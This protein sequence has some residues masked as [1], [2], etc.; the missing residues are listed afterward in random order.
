MLP[1]SGPTRVEALFAHAPGASEPGGAGAGSCLL[2]F[3]PG[4]NIVLL[5]SEPRDGW[6]YGLNE[7]TGRWVPS[8]HLNNVA[9]SEVMQCCS[10][11]CSILEILAQSCE[12][13]LVL[14]H[15]EFPKSLPNGTKWNSPWQERLVPVLLHSASSKQVG[16]SREVS[17][18]KPMFICL[19]CW[20]TLTISFHYTLLNNDSC[21]CTTNEEEKKILFQKNCPSCH[22]IPPFLPSSLLHPAP[23]SCLKPTATAQGSLTSWCLQQHSPQSQRRNSRFPRRGSAPSDLARTAWPT[24]TRSRNKQTR[25][26]C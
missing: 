1:L 2:H 6:H 22:F 19:F 8:N 24:A 4:D 14:S 17:Q 3:L 23:S 9:R 20:W 11:T 7:R 26:W 13:F 12:G 10:F 15:C 5:I 21:W 16:S 18:W 25:D